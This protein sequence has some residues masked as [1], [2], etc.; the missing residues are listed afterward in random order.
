MSDAPATPT[1]KRP[2]IGSGLLTIGLG[3]TI[4]YVG[5]VLFYWQRQEASISDLSPNEFGDFLAGLCSPLAFLWLVLGFIQQGIELRN[6]SDAL[7][8]QGEELR[9]SVEQQRDLVNVTREQLAFEAANLAQQREELV[10]NSQPLFVLVSAGNMTEPSSKLRRFKFRII[11]IGKPCTDAAVSVDGNL[12]ARTSLVGTSG[13]M[14]FEILEEPDWT[15]ERAGE[16]SF[17]DERLVARTRGFTITRTDGSGPVI[18]LVE[19]A[20]S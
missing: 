1:Q 4:L 6:S 20:E 2:A 12:R 16:I 14:E 13:K 17:Y 9:H 11:N 5:L 10:R 7:H 3:I 15:G 8:L 18:E 19:D